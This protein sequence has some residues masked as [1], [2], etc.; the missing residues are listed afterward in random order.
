[1]LRTRWRGGSGSTV[2][3]PF[4]HT[5][6]QKMG[7]IEDIEEPF[8]YRIPAPAFSVVTELDEKR[9]GENT[10]LKEYSERSTD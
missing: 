10:E 8:M 9:N 5:Q 2:L 4:Q 3:E 7:R 6:Q 1:M